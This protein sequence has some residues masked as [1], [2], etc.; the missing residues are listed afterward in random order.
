MGVVVI[1]GAS[2][3]SAGLWRPA[4]GR[5]DNLFAPV[6]LEVATAGPFGDETHEQAVRLPASV[7]RGAL[8]L[9]AVA[10]AAGLAALGRFSKNG[11][12]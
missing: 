12:G 1:T 7:A 9:S 6:E 4:G 5:P 10:A 3:A 8:A 11:S 2:G